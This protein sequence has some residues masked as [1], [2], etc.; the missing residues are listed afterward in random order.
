MVDQEDKNSAN[1]YESDGGE[2]EDEEVKRN[3][4]MGECGDSDYFDSDT[5]VEE[6]EETEDQID[7][8]SNETVEEDRIV[9][10]VKFVSVGSQILKPKGIT[11]CRPTP[12]V[13]VTA[14]NGEKPNEIDERSSTSSPKM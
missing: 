12:I 3:C 7:C 9:Q 11:L 8:K 1:A 4:I 13:L 10:L 5:D 6:E 14:T 2:T